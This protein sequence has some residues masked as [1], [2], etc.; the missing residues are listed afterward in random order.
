[1]K[2]NTKILVETKQNSLYAEASESV[3]DTLP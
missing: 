2:E 1:M 3:E